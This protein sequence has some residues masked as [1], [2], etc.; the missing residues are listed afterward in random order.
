MGAETFKIIPLEGTPFGMNYAIV[1]ESTSL[2]PGSEWRSCTRSAQHAR[3]NITTVSPGDNLLAEV[4]VLPR[5]NI[6]I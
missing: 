6:K 2:S 4:L 1:N 5:L 3:K